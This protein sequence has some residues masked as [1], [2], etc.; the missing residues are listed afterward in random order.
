MVTMSYGYNPS[1]QQPIDPAPSN[2]G[3]VNPVTA[4][5]AAQN[6]NTAA[7]IYAT[8]T[9]P[10]L[11]MQRRENDKRR[12]RDYLHTAQRRAQETN[13]HFELAHI[14]YR[15]KVYLLNDTKVMMDVIVLDKNGN[16]K[17]HSTRDVTNEDFG[18][19]M[20]DLSQGK[21]LFVDNAPGR[22]SYY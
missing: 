9:R 4:V 20:D 18:R 7:M 22:D 5:S 19:F 17:R 11:K 16:P 14:P 13:Q 1:M 12:I 15:I 8:F 6:L 21:G 2:S 3:M 10:S